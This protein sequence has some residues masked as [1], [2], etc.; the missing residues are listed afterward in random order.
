MMVLGI[1]LSYLLHYK[2]PPADKILRIFLAFADAELLFILNS[3][4]KE[5]A[6]C[7]YSL[8][9]TQL[10][11]EGGRPKAALVGSRSRG[12]RRAAEGR[13]WLP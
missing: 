4:F 10:F 3:I 5:T 2:A 11:V 6:I 13:S 12:L 8:L 7:Y 9:I 1:V